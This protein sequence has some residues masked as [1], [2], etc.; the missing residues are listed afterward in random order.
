MAPPQFL[1]NQPESI[2]SLYS[3]KVEEN[4]DAVEDGRG[5]TVDGLGVVEPDDEDHE[6][7]DKEVEIKNAVE[8]ANVEDIEDSYRDGYENDFE[9]LE[10]SL[11]QHIPLER[12]NAKKSAKS[13]K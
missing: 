5:A 1:N 10:E 11:K 8:M 13:L 12:G 6:E 7:C 4:P 9:V 3:R 2:N